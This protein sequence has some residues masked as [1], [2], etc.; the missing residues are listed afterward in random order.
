MELSANSELVLLC[1]LFWRSVGRFRS[2]RPVRACVD[3]KNIDCIG[4][5]LVCIHQC[6]RS[7]SHLM[8][9]QAFCIGDVFSCVL[10]IK[11]QSTRVHMYEIKKKFLNDELP[12][13]CWTLMD[14]GKLVLVSWSLSSWSSSFSWSRLGGQR[15]QKF[16]FAWKPTEVS[17]AEQSLSLSSLVVTLCRRV[18]QEQLEESG[19]APQCWS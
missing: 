14:L 3:I 9:F 2:N 6:I 19:M 1:Y 13:W 10:E 12:G 7:C 15:L 8:L 16:V 4:L 11:L 18:H 5:F 17:L